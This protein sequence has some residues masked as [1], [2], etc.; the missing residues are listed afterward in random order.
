MEPSTV[1]QPT[2]ETPAAPTGMPVFT[3]DMIP[4]IACAIGAGF[5]G[6][7][8]FGG[9]GGSLLG[10]ALYS[11]FLKSLIFSEGQEKNGSPI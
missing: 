8:Y 5:A 1:T 6:K 9:I 11:V 4:K 7:H 10:V 3:A 2:A